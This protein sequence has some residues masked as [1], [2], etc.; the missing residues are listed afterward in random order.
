MSPTT[1]LCIFVGIVLGVKA[2]PTLRDD[3]DELE[4]TVEWLKR[5]LKDVTEELEQK[6][7]NVDNEVNTF[8]QQLEP[9]NRKVTN[10]EK[11]IATI[12]N[13]LEYG[14]KIFQTYPYNRK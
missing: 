8:Q 6:L 4:Q 10:S 1:I 14:G 5:K 11:K 3:V 7:D 9:L 13:R 2:H 12:Q